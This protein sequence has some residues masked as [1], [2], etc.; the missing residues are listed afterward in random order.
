MT[1]EPTPKPTID[2][3]LKSL[4][5]LAVKPHHQNCPQGMDRRLRCEC[6]AEFHNARVDGS[7]NAIVEKIR[8]PAPKQGPTVPAA[9]ALAPES[10]PS[11]APAPAPAPA[12]FTTGT[13]LPGIDIPVPVSAQQPAQMPVPDGGLGGKPPVKKGAAKVAGN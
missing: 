6:G 12:Q 5:K 1:N 9:E 11:P 10:S 4:R 13:S 3:L 2:D 8:E 7:L